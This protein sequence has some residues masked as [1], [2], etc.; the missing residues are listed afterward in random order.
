MVTLKDYPPWVVLVF[1]V[2]RFKQ[3]GAA[4]HPK[5][6]ASSVRDKCHQL[7]FAISSLN[8]ASKANF[9]AGLNLSFDKGGGASRSH[10]NPAR[11]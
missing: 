5:V 4:F 3:I 2:N 11:Q 10:M 9:I 6:G 7:R 1:S 8:A